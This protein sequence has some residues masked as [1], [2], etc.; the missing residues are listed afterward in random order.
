MSEQANQWADQ[1]AAV[2]E[3]I[4]DAVFDALRDQARGGPGT[5]QAKELERQL[6]RVRRSLDKAEQILRHLDTDT[7]IES[8]DEA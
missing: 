2:T 7:S 8:D 3:Q 6:S 4:G 5:E 1:V